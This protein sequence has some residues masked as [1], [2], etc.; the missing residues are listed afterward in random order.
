MT[1][2]GNSSLSWRSRWNNSRD[3]LGWVLATALVLSMF[4]VFPRIEESDA[5]EYFSYLPSL[6]FDQDLDFTNEYQYFY[7]LDPEGRRGF[8]QTFL[9][10]STPTGL[11]LNFGPIGCALLWAPFY[12]LAHLWLW[13]QSLFGIEVVADGLS[14]TY[15]GFVA[16]GSAFYGALGLWLSYRLSRRWAD[17]LPAFVL[18]VALWWGTPVA[19]YMY[20]APG[21]SHSPSLFAVALFFTLWPWVSARPDSYARWLLWGAAV[22]LMAL[23]R[24]QDGLFAVTTLVVALSPAWTAAP[25]E[26]CKRL[27]S[28]ALCSLVVFSPQLLVYIVLYGRP[29]PSHHVQNKMG[30]HSP[31]FFEVLF[32]VQH[33]LFFWT[34]LLLLCVGGGFWLYRRDRIAALVVL[35][36]FFSQVY[37]SGAV[38]SWTQ[39][40]AFGSRRFVGATVLFAIMGAYLYQRLRPLVGVTGLAVTSLFLVSWN[41]SLMIQFGLGI[42]DRQRLDWSEITHNFFYEVPSRLADVVATFTSSPGQLKGAP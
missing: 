23:I 3:P 35:A 21:M 11:K 5:V 33:G 18:V 4:L 15:R 8:K 40:G 1:A 39:A 26:K 22:G 2:I 7:D 12:L 38:D 42:M 20:I 6:L 25:W 19:Y 16:V 34:P 31:H 32:S 9:D 17:D 37:I 14:Q 13:I 10:R 30:W 36:G 24:E 29:A 27:A 28:A 41:V